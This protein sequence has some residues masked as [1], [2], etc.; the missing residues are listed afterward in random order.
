[1]APSRSDSD[2]Q[3]SETAQFLQHDLSAEKI[4]RIKIQHAD[5]EVDLKKGKGGDWTLPGDWPARKK[6]VEELVHLLAG[7]KSRFATT[8]LANVDDLKTYGLAKPPVVI[9]VD[10]GQGEHRLAFGEESG[11]SNR[12]SRPTYAR[13]DDRMEVVRLAPGIVDTL[14]RPADHYQQRRLF[15]SERVAKDADSQEKVERLTAK[16]IS[17]KDAK[18]SYSLEKA[19]DDWEIREP[20]RDRADPDKL[21]TILS[22]VPDVWAEQFVDKPKSDLAEYGLKDPQETISIVGSNGEKIKLLIGKQSQVKTRTVMRPAPN[23]G[24]PPM[25]PQQEV[26]HDEFRYAKLDGNPQIFEIKADKLKDIFSTADALRDARL[27]R[28]RTEDARKVEIAQG[29][30]TIVLAKDKDRWKVQKPM[31]VDAEPSKITELLDKL[32]GLQAR[33]K[34]VLDKA[35]AKAYGLDKPVATVKV[36]VEEE[37][38]GDTKAKKTKTF[39]FDLGKHDTDQSK[40]YVRLEDVPRIN[41]VEDSVLK[42]VERPALAYRGRRVL[43][44]PTTELAKIEVKRENG[45]YT[46]E[47]IKDSW[48]LAAPVQADIDSAKAS[49]LAS[50]LARLEAIEYV[51]ER[52]TPDALDRLYGLGKPALSAQITFTDA[53]KPAQTL[54]IGKQREGKPEYFARLTSAP[55]MFVVK[56]EL[57]DALDQDSLA[58]RPLQLWQLTEDNIKELKIQKDDPQYRLLHDGQNWKIAGPFDAPAVTDIV[59]PMADE[60]SNPRCERYVAHNAKELTTYGLDKPYLRA[61]VLEGKKETAPT[62]KG[63]PK[64]KATKP[65]FTERSLI[66]GKPA[67]KDGKTRFAKLGAGDAVFVVGEKLVTAIDHRALDLLQRDLQT[68]DSAAIEKIRNEGA[69]DALTIQ[70]EG[71]DWR[72]LDSPAAPFTAD[73]EA[74]TALLGVWSNLKAS[75]YAAYGTKLDLPAYGLDKPYRTVTVSL[76]AAPGNAAKTT[77]AEHRL[78]LGKAVQGSTGERFARL[79][80]GPGVVVL[81]AN[82]A[83][84]LTHGYL[85]FVNRSVLKLDA[86]KV[87]GIERTMGKDTIEIVRRDGSWHLIKPAQFP[88]D[89]PTLDGLIAQLSALRAKRVAA[90]PAKDLKAFGLDAPAAMV[91]IRGGDSSGKPGQHTIKIGMAGDPGSADRFAQVDNSTAVVV[92]PDSLSR[93]MVAA[94]L[95]FRDRNLAHVGGIDRVVLERGPR[96]ATFAKSDGTWKLTQPL[97]GEAE[98]FDLDDFITAISRLRADELVAEK[99]RDLKLYGLERPEARWKFQ[100]GDKAVLDLVVGGLEKSKSPKA[101]EADRRYAKLANSDVVFLLSPA[102][103]TKALTEY[104][105]RNLWASLDAA[106]IDKLHYGYPH[107]PF[108]LEKIDNDW[109]VSGQ[110]GAKVK[111]DAIR[112][113]L[114]ALAGLKAVRY[115]ADKGADLKLYGLEPP[116]CVLEIQTPTGKRVLQIGRPEGE[117]KR[118]Y[119]RVP[120]GDKSDAV[121][122][123]SETDAARIVRPLGAFFQNGAKVS[124]A[125]M[126]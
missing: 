18:T 31:D 104:R 115:V 42:L 98:S 109:R 24:G 65:A 96:K 112:E 17:A 118:L 57:R 34:D 110:P 107:D 53:K 19:G 58:L 32:S 9:T 37:A 66:I 47:Q 26:I 45:P 114:D 5:R 84:E 12:F 60:L 120:E 80:N 36:S 4:Q 79:D 59:K 35:D 72:V 50:D 8:A 82:V 78:V 28:F 95:H 46:L 108:T 88:A 119:A 41:A 15:P 81:A 14:D 93:D 103:T 20:V 1:L 25:P 99:P 126:H 121:F 40:I 77:P 30:Q 44:H 13:L 125:P 117:S 22:A 56:K 116:Q 100:S 71:N 68:L 86:A 69:G 48:R 92:L 97:E 87:T 83:N 55:S 6:E 113:A 106:Q 51:S 105:S 91:T 123:I 85:D 10:I 2:N 63:K 90:Y 43:D 73:T 29:N 89:G 61:T 94:D 111:A 70:R 11:D 52:A 3:T 124:A 64:D 23:I 75:R 62:E 49:T 67:D 16:S 74:V 122:V 39:V 33:D 27:A 101:K 54:Q 102:L 76:K 21:K 38:K 7:L